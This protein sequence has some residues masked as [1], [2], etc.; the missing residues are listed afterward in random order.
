MRERAGEWTVQLLY[1]DWAVTEFRVRVFETAQDEAAVNRPPAPVSAT[2]E[3]S[4]IDPARAVWARIYPDLVN[5]DP[6]YDLVRYTYRWFVNGA[7]VRTITTA[8]HADAI[9][10]SLHGAGDVVTCEVTADDG[11]RGACP[12]DLNSDNRVDGV[13]L[14]VLLA[15]WGGPGGDLSGDGVTGSEDLA[16]LLSSWG[17]CG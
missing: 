16:A 11:V 8:G 17:A 13:D 2:L 15:S 3:P 4:V 5:D 6:D 14:A 1:F 7:P 10:A 9:P 12:A